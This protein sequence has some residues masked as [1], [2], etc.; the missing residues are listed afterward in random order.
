MLEMLERAAPVIPVITLQE[1]DDWLGLADCL[2]QAGVNT[3]EI[4]LRT[5]QGLQAIADL[6]RRRPQ[7]VVGAGTVLS[8]EQV[9]AAAEA[10]A[11]FLVSPGID[12]S[13]LDAAQR[14]SIPYLPGTA[15]VSEMMTAQAAGL[16]CAKLFPA[17]VVGGVELL[18][19]AGSV[20]PD[21]TL[22]PTGGVSQDNLD[23]Y[24]ALANV[25]CVGGSWLCP[26][27]AVTAADW[28]LIDQLAREA[29]RS[30]S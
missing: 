1:G 18:K 8:A 22:C 4:T 24:L 16:A 25:A 2:S 12:T 13:L 7:I 26:A 19:A 29:V 10:G 17:A 28:A 14:I 11:Q 6:R 21:L 23:E 3:L 30:N 9:Q 15:T 20:L 5:D 27:S